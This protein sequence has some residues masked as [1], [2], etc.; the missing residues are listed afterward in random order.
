M[1]ANQDLVQNYT[2]DAFGAALGVQS[3]ANHQR[4]VGTGGVYSDDDS[5]LQYMWNRWYNPALGR[6]VSRDP[7]GIRG[8]L[9]LYSYL[10]NNPLRGV[11]PL[12][13][14]GQSSASNF[15]NQVGVFLGNASENVGNL[16]NAVGAGL[17][18]NMSNIKSGLQ[19]FVEDAGVVSAVTGVVGNVTE[20]LSNSNYK[21]ILP[22]V[23]HGG[24]DFIMVDAATGGTLARTGDPGQ[25]AL[26]GQI[27]HEMIT[28]AF[29]KYFP[30]SP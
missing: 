23:I 5:G 19:E 21:Q 28:D 12:G 20:D 24:V 6:F 8:G 22:D 27:T 25:A 14:C 1:D 2:Y 26:N 4:Y 18:S 7:I 3:D 11:D 16:L 29:D 13:L 30:R 15:F 9:N 10:T 17:N